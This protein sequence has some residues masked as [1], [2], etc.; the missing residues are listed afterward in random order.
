MQTVS[1]TLIAIYIA[2]LNSL[3]KITI[4]KSKHKYKKFLNIEIQRKSIKFC[5][6]I[7][8]KL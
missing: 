1:A 6:D 4:S 2:M 7:R 8:K 3:N 5:S